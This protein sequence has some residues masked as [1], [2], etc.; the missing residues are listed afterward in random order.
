DVSCNR[1]AIAGPPDALDQIQ[2]L[3]R[4]VRA[5]H[6][7]QDLVG[8]GL[9]RQ[10]NVLGKFWQSGDCV[11]QVVAETDRM[12]G[13]ETKSLKAFDLVNGLEQLHERRLVVDLRKSVA[14][15][16]IHDLPKK[17]DFFV[18]ARNKNAHFCPDLADGPAASRSKR[19]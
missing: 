8:A 13:S 7:F 6:C 19:L 5:V 18:A 16:K 12:R 14:T 9:Q 4:G 10:M 15:V 2:I 1:N 3:L 17:R 11:D